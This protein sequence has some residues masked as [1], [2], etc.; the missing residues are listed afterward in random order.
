MT[1]TTYGSAG[2]GGSYCLGGFS[3]CQATTYNSGGNGYVTI[4]FVQ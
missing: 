1:T 3:K 2:G 4:T